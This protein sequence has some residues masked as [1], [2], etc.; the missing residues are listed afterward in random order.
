MTSL[1]PFRLLLITIFCAD[2]I[3]IQRKL[4]PDSGRD[5][6]FLIINV[7]QLL[8]R[9]LTFPG[10]HSPR[11]RN[12]QTVFSLCGRHTAGVLNSCA[13]IRLTCLHFRV[14]PVLTSDEHVGVRVRVCV[15]VQTKR[16]LFEVS[17]FLSFLNG[18][19]GLNSGSQSCVTSSFTC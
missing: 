14:R 11:C 19:Q 7:S 4:L 12:T 17:S 9:S 13:D 5:V 3:L 1:M 15:R 18:L 8:L 10:L 2:S 6:Q 16:Q